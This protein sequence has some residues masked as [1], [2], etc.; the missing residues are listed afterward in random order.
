[1]LQWFRMGVRSLRLPF[2]V[3]FIIPLFIFAYCLAAFVI[4]CFYRPYGGET[5]ME[6]LREQWH[7]FILWL[8]DTI[9]H[10]KEG[11]P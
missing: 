9:K 3:L 2:F 8:R 10:L 1:M 7:E 5:V 6:V 4:V 11:K